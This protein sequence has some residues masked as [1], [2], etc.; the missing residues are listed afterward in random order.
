MSFPSQAFTFQSTSLPSWPG[1]NNN[2]EELCNE[3]EKL[4][5]E[6][7][8]AN[9]FAL[10]EGARRGKNTRKLDVYRSDDGP[11]YLKSF[12]YVTSLGNRLSRLT[13]CKLCN[14]LKQMCLNP[15]KGTYKLLAIC[16]SE[17]YLFE[18]PKKANRSRPP[19]RPWGAIDHNVF[20]AV[21]PEVPLIP[22]IGIPLRWLE[23]ELPMSGSIYRLSL[24]TSDERLRLAS[25]RVVGPKADFELAKVWLG[26][27]RQAHKCC[28]PKKPVGV[29]LPGFRVVNCMRTPLVV[30]DR[31]WWTRYVALSYVWGP[32]SVSDIS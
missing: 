4:D 9:A 32:L 1:G 22:K 3:C 27:C 7:S 26:C 28:A 12:Y 30:E 8:F 5:L 19:D 20:M 15:S 31:P 10:Y 23:T 25:P 6:E 13:T 11:A 2:I 18:I 17:S 14:F 24:S 29:S 21:V 16:S